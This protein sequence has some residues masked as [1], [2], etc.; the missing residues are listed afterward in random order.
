M[1]ADRPI[2]PA[3][4]RLAA[5]HP[6]RPLTGSEYL[7]S[8]RDD[9]EIWICGKRVADV[10]TDPAFQNTAR[11]LARFYD[12]LH[13]PKRRARVTMETDTGNGGYTHRFFRCSRTAEELVAAR[14]AIA[15]TASISY[16]WMGRTPDYKGALV[17]A[18]GACPE[19]YAPFEENA[20][21]WY[22]ILQ[23][24]VAFV[25]H[26]VVN[27]H[28]DRERPPEGAKDAFM[29]VVHESDAGLVIS[30]AKV[31]ATT[32][33]LTH[34][35][36]VSCNGPVKAREFFFVCLV[37]TNGRGVKLICRPSYEMAAGMC[38]TPFDYPLSSRLDENDS[39]LVFDRV[40]VPWENVLSYRVNGPPDAHRQ[41]GF[42]PRATLQSCTRLAVKMNF[43][44]GLVLRVAEAGGGRISRSLQ[45]QTGELLAWRHI[46]WA[47]S[48]A[49]V[50]HPVP[51]ENGHVLPNP[52][53][54]LAF[55]VLAN[56]VY[57]KIREIGQ[58]LFADAAA[59]L[60]TS[61]VCVAVPTTRPEWA[62]A[63]MERMQPLQLLWDAIGTEFGTR[64]ELYERCHLGS[65]DS[66]RLEVLT[67]AEAD[68][69]TATFKALADR[70]MAEYDRHG[71]TVTD[72]VSPTNDGTALKSPARSPHARRK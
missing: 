69:S 9:R 13:D 20:R 24:D 48:D 32:S 31:V 62:D 59:V 2:H 15:E 54:G 4:L 36:F 42:L 35:T 65:R 53:Y 51:W 12:A 19:Y 55:R 57:P 38:G 22:R 47:L 43:L 60:G 6:P 56:A 68:G 10:T 50:H 45:A 40:L 58:M 3:E 70:C 61:A 1:C 17:G 33:C 66:V 30:G 18:M 39:I 23:E 14:N 26:A 28:I 5:P 21:R 11:M 46:F 16:G 64:H 25:N 34:Y 41:S 52:A 8:L 71:W 37:P 63:A 49:M 44:S 72:L 7:E 27:P 29:H 67:A